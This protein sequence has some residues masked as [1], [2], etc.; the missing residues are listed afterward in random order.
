MYKNKLEQDIA[1]WKYRHP[2]LLNCCGLVAFIAMLLVP[3]AMI[4]LLK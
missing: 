2:K 1:L 4:A 3:V